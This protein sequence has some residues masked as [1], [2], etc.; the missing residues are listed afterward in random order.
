MREKIHKEISS[1]EKKDITGA[2]NVIH[3]TQQVKN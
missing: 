2:G 3:T 1:E